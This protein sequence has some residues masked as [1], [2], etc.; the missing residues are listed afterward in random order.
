MSEQ[1]PAP[2]AAGPVAI[3]IVDDHAMFRRGVRAE[4]RL[5]PRL[6]STAARFSERSR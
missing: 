1:Q 5:C 6:A 4:L 2:R 3:V